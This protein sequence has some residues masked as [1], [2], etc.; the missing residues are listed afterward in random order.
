LRARLENEIKQCIDYIKTSKE[1]I[2]RYFV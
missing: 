1:N 2:S